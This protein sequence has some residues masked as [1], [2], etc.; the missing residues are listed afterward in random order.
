MR[1]TVGAIGAERDRFRQQYEALFKQHQD[2]ADDIQNLQQERERLR[3]QVEDMKTSSSS[4]K[5]Q[6]IV[7][8][9]KPVMSP[10]SSSSSLAKVNLA[11]PFLP[12]DRMSSTPK[13]KPKAANGAL[14]EPPHQAKNYFVVHKE[15]VMEAPKLQ[16]S[17]Q[18]HFYHPQQIQQHQQLQ[19][20]IDRPNVHQLYQQHQPQQ[21]PQVQYHQQRFQRR[22]EP[23]NAD[24]DGEEEDDDF[25]DEEVVP[26]QRRNNNDEDVV[27][28]GFHEAG[29]HPALN[30]ADFGILQQPQKFQRQQVPMNGLQHNRHNFL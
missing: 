13:S 27:Y 11:E 1:Q 9:I 19:Q 2:S 18:Q 28:N 12:N 7:K 23:N 29:Q 22:H 6:P 16:E 5:P 25:E 17:F 4:I 20:P 14:Q 30:P 24:D 8:Q 3:L 15:D 10:S 21:H 26:L